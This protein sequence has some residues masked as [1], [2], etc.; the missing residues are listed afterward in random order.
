MNSIETQQEGKKAL[1]TKFYLER[2]AC[3][4][5]LPSDHCLELVLFPKQR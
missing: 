1:L 5:E 2:E 4:S 3:V